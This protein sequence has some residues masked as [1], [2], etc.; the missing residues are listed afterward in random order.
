M[1]VRQRLGLPAQ[2]IGDFR[3]AVTDVDAPQPGHSVHVP[4]SGGILEPDALA[5]HHD[6]RRAVP[7]MPGQGRKRMEVVQAIDIG[8]CRGGARGRRCCAHV[9]IEAVTTSRQTAFCR[10]RSGSIDHQVYQFDRAWNSG[11]GKTGKPVLLQPD[12]CGPLAACPG[13][14]RAMRQDALGRK[15][16]IFRCEGAP[17][18]D[19]WTSRLGRECQRLNN[20]RTANLATINPGIC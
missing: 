19:R 8:Q 16:G 15:A 7:F 5:P 10:N 9:V 11:V 14:G 18:L 17:S 13:F 2:R 4:A 6:D 1:T 3:A 20:G 12:G